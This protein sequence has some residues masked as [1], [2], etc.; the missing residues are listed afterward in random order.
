MKNIFLYGEHGNE[1]RKFV[2]PP[3]PLT[4]KQ[5]WKLN[6]ISS[7]TAEFPE[8]VDLEYFGSTNF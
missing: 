5:G 7:F 3:R 8:S 6:H 1:L 2:A 4:L